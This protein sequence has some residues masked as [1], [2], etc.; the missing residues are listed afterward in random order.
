MYHLEILE[1]SNGV[2]NVD[3]VSPNTTHEYVH[4]WQQQ[5]QIAR[6]Q[7]RKRECAEMKAAQLE[8]NLG[9]SASFH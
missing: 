9:E 5:F 4:V 2:P 1:S 7:Q 3:A 6:A 8:M